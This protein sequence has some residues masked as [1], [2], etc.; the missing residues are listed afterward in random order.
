MLLPKDD[1]DIDKLLKYVDP[2]YS[3]PRTP[4]VIFLTWMTLMKWMPCPLSPYVALTCQA[5]RS[6]LTESDARCPLSII[7]SSVKLVVFSPCQ[8]TGFSK[9]LTRQNGCRMPC[10]LRIYFVEVL[11]D[12]DLVVRNT[13]AHGMDWKRQAARQFRLRQ[14]TCLAGILIN[15][16]GD[17][18]RARG[19]EVWISASI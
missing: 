4:M 9:A 17:E 18:L 14:E 16:Q 11:D 1:L 12:S 2:S 7:V 6:S 15:N 3:Y 19:S 5:W 8:S 10:P 13:Q